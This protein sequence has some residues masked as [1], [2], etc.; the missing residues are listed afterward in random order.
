MNCI[1]S[2]SR[3]DQGVTVGS[4]RNKRLLSADDLVLLASSQQSS[5]WTRSVFCCVNRAGMKISTKNTEV[6]RLSA[7]L[8]QCVRQVSSNTPQQVEKFKYLGVVFTSNG[9][10]SARKLIY[11]LVREM[12]FSVSFIAL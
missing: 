11:G 1:D 12:Q 9:R 7:N 6:L 10:R 5:A 3:V 2:H 8:R 4:C